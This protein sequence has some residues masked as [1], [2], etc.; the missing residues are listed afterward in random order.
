MYEDPEYISYMTEEIHPDAMDILYNI[1]LD[2][3]EY[4]YDLS[5]ITYTENGVDKTVLSLM[6]SLWEELKIE[7]NIGTSVY[8]ICGVIVF[9]AVSFG[10]VMYIRKKKRQSYYD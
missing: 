5:S 2:K 7:S 8:V 6:N 1:D 3:M 10:M 4:F 9:T